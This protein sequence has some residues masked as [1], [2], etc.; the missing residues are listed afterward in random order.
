MSTLTDRYLAATLRALPAQRREEI[1]NELRASIAD[2]IE[3]RTAAGQDAATAE[4]EVLTELGHPERLAARYA[5]HRLQLIGPTYY[6]IWR[7]VLRLTLGVALPTVG[8]LVGLLDAADGNGIGSAIATGVT[9]A[10]QVAVQV[11]FWV[12]LVF[13]I[14]ERAFPRPD[15]P[16]WSV[17]QLPDDPA[18]R[19]ERVAPL[20]DMAVSIAAL[21]LTIAFLPWQ[22]FRSWVSDEAGG[23]IP[24]I[25]PA[26]WRSWLPVLIAVLVCQIVLAVVRYRAGGWTVPLVGM[27][28]ALDLAFAVPLAW[29][30]LSDRLLNPDFVQRV[31]WLRDG[32]NLDT[33]YRVALVVVALVLAWNTVGNL[34]AAQRAR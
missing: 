2:M 33:V 20:A 5:D 15:G 22:H 6:L 27:K 21:L 10:I 13:A 12:T 29:L 16:A 3:G 7:R 34:R 30:V 28:L 24:V 23:S 9:T 19:A 25:D 14:A 31:D 8:I 4:R 18:E 26:L 32:A 1:A 11:A 17:D